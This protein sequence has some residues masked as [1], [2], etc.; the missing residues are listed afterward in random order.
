MEREYFVYMLT[1]YHKTVLYIGVT[2]NLVARIF[3]HKDRKIAGFTKRYNVS[4][5]VYYELYDDISYAI[6]REKQLKKWSRI[7]KN[8]LVSSFNPSWRDLYDEIV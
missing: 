3:Q 1:N 2:N 4:R 6:A 5:L 7:K 8:N